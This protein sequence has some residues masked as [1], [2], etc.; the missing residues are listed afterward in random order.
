M[1]SKETCPL[2]GGPARL[3]C[4]KPPSEYYLSERL[5]LIYQRA[6]PSVARM[7]QYAD[8]EYKSGVYKDYTSA[9]ELKRATFERRLRRLEALGVT[10]GRL[11]DVGCACGFF[12]EAALAHGFDAQGVEF[13]REAI[14]AAREDI[15]GR[16]TQGDVNALR[17]RDTEP[18]DVIVAFD[19][20]EHTQAP[21]VFLEELRGM[22]RPGGWLVLATP[23]TGHFLRYLMGSRWPMLQPLQHTY[24]FSK[25]AMRFALE[26]TGFEDIRLSNADKSLQLDYL[27]EQIRIHNPTLHRAYRLIAPLL[28]ASLRQRTFA[29]NIGEMLAF[30]RNPS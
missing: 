15:R 10:K 22:L 20:I 2:S 26:K 21:L 8:E 30:A 3:Y 29:V 6:A 5:G 14:A 18:F 28:P 17:A 11:L 7:E 12:I 27:A 4:R 23:D 13:S 16:I 19:I 1:I 24:L 25:K 9:G